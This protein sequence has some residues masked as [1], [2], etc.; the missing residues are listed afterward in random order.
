MT[1]LFSAM[2]FYYFMNGDMI[3]TKRAVY[4]FF[5]L[6]SFIDIGN[7]FKSRKFKILQWRIK[8]YFMKKIIQMRKFGETYHMLL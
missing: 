6:N 5:R 3:P 2:S 4:I 1:F 8:Y 7:R